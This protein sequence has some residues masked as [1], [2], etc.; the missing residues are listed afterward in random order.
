MTMHMTRNRARKASGSAIAETGPALLILFMALFFPLCNL[1]GMGVSYASCFTLNDVQCREASTLPKLQAEAAGGPIKKDVVERWKKS[2]F[3]AFVQVQG[4][5]KTEVNYFKGVKDNNDT[6]DQIV[7]VTTT[8]TSK[9]F[10][11]VP[12]PVQV[13]ALNAPVSFTISNRRIVENHHFVSG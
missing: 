10:L 2:G 4:N 1:L 13:P 3:G 8:L 6:E 7:E 12:F 9:P 11:M 5:V